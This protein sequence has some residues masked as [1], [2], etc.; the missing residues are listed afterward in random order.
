[1]PGCYVASRKAYLN[2]YVRHNALAFTLSDLREEERLA[3]ANRRSKTSFTAEQARKDDD[4]TLEIDREKS[5]ERMRRVDVIAGR[6]QEDFPDPLPPEEFEELD[7]DAQK[8]H[9]HKRRE[10]AYKLAKRIEERITIFQHASTKQEFYRALEREMKRSHSLARERERKL[11]LSPG[12]GGSQRRDALIFLARDGTEKAGRKSGGGSARDLLGISPSPSMRDLSSSVP[13][14]PTAEQASGATYVEPSLAGHDVRSLVNAQLKHSYRILSEDPPRLRTLTYPKLE[15]ALSV[16]SHEVDE[17]GRDAAFEME[18]AH[19]SLE[20]NLL[21][22]MRKEDKKQEMNEWSEFRNLRKMRMQ[23]DAAHLLTFGR[24]EEKSG[25]YP[26]EGLGRRDRDDLGGVLAAMS[27]VRDPLQQSPLAKPLSVIGSYALDPS[28]DHKGFVAVPAERRTR[29]PKLPKDPN[30]QK[31]VLDSH[32]NALLYGDTSLKKTSSS[33]LGAFGSLNE[34]RG[35]MQG[36]A[37]LLASRDGKVDDPTDVEALRRKAE[38]EVKGLTPSERSKRAMARLTQGDLALVTRLDAHRN[39]RTGLV[40]LAFNEAKEAKEARKKAEEAAIEAAKAAAEA[41]GTK[42]PRPSAE[43]LEEIDDEHHPEHVL[44]ANELQASLAVRYELQR[45]PSPP[46]LGNPKTLAEHTLK[47]T[48]APAPANAMNHYEALGHED[49]EHIKDVKERRKANLQ[50]SSD[51]SA[52]RASE[53]ML[54]MIGLP[55]GE[56]NPLADEDGQDEEEEEEEAD[57]PPSP[58]AEDGGMSRSSRSSKE[59]Q[60]PAPAPT[61]K[62][63]TGK[64]TGKE[65][66]SLAAD[67]RAKRSNT[68]F[69]RTQ[70][71]KAVSKGPQAMSQGAPGYEFPE[72]FDPLALLR[73]GR[74]K[75]LRRVKSLVEHRAAPQLMPAVLAGRGPS[76]VKATAARHQLIPATKLRARRIKARSELLVMSR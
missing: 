1:M 42:A 43:D 37:A 26:E 75:E 45:Q 52:R 70:S 8:E 65:A 18:R 53:M 32:Q 13:T 55:A 22:R 30:H 64:D 44:E 67:L 54:G 59:Q 23:L 73:I 28:A 62:D 60:T 11:A 72:R 51:G 69:R 5:V 12:G 63:P 15:R 49:N 46:R 6:L 66:G 33:I 31:T 36:L 38:E 35:S 19:A 14:S 34:R 24:D 29:D 21:R 4:P 17:H 20:L 50:A 71:A 74:S 68:G 2:H 61:K 9:T 47:T 41:E 40:S 48:W 25:P 57:P 7:D 56:E 16:D 76:P 10:Q 58:A 39:V 3:K 27:S